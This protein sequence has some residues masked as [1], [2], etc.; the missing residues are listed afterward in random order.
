[1]NGKNWAN[2]LSP[3]TKIPGYVTD[4]VISGQYRLTCGRM[5]TPRV[6]GQQLHG[7]VSIRTGAGY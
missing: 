3:K 5:V 2:G 4:D 1:M 7:L 6:G